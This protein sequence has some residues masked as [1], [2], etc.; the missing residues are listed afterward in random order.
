MSKARDR[1]TTYRSKRDFKKT[2]E[3]AG[4]PRASGRKLSYLIQ[5]HA[6]SHEHY[7]FR[8]EWNGALLSWAVPKGPSENPDDKRLAIHVEDHPVEYG[9]FEG[10]IPKDEYGGGTVMLWDRGTWTPDGDVEAGLEKG[11]L[12]FELHGERLKGH[13][14]LVRLRARSKNDKDNWLLIK[15]LAGPMPRKGKLIVERE[16]T[17]V[18][19]WGFTN[20]GSG[21]A[22]FFFTRLDF[23]FSVLSLCALAAADLFECQTL[24]PCAISPMVRPLATLVISR[25]T[26]SLPFR[27][28]G[29][30]SS[31]ISSQLSLS[32]LL[33]ARRRTSAQCPFSRSPCS[34][35]LSLPF[36]S[37]ASTSPSGVQ[38]PRSHSITVPPPYSSF[39]MVP[40]NLPYSTG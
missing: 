30:A 22:G 27:G 34:S 8:L 36:S 14:A 3:P 16:M 39:G 23:V 4:T 10:T 6:A 21:P 18:A 17:S 11:K 28:M 25:S 9:K 20:A 31:L 7:D 5:K 37:P 12:S 2:R 33:R 32:F 38:V 26:I 1:L 19:S 24:A 15:E 35:K 29:P 13:W 40:S